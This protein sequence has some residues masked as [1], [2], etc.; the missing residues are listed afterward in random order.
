M[1]MRS[2]AIP[3]GISILV[4]GYFFSS[5]TFGSKLSQAVAHTFSAQAG[6]AQTQ[7][8]PIPGDTPEAQLTQVFAR[9]EKNQLDLALEQAEALT[10]KYPT[11]RLGQLVKG[12]LLLA[13]AQ[14]ISTFGNVNNAPQDKLADL[15]DE[16]LA[17][18]R[19]YRSQP[20]AN[21]IPEYLLQLQPEQK[22]AIVVDTQLSRLYLYQNDDGTP[23]LINNYYISQGKLGADKFR[24]GDQKTP[25]GVYRIVGNLTRDKIGDFYGGGAWPLNYPNDWDRRNGRNGHGIWLHG[26][27]SDTY[28]RPPKASNGCVVLANPD[29]DTVASHLQIGL[30]PVVIASSVDWLTPDEWKSER[31]DILGAIDSWRRD[32]ES[33]DG[34]RYASHYSTTFNADGIDYTTWTAQKLAVNAS[35]SWIRVD[36][37]KLTL[38]RYPGKDDMV[39][40]TFMQDYKSNNLNNS[41]MKRQYWLKENGQWKII[42]EGAA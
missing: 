1:R 38:F 9:I 23:K 7:L 40:A 36:T 14:P 2:L 35:K 22:Y 41:M 34:Q 13:R 11:F 25:L 32:W 30:T 5:D 3:A 39:V 37:D 6:E 19:A 28:S 24:E 8:T 42:Y 12:D 29:L 20:P 15:R 18:L 21:S 16:A 4:A 17:R 26:V 31:K 10:D 33:R 27:P